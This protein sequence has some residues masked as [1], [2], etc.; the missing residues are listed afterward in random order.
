MRYYTK[1]D[2]PDDYIAINHG[3]PFPLESIAERE[4]V[5]IVDYSIS[6]VD[7]TTLLEKTE[8]V[9][10]MDHPITAINYYQDY[11]KKIAGIR[12]VGIAGCQLTYAY[13][14]NADEKSN[15]EICEDA[16][17]FF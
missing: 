1:E 4:N 12:F 7:M 5:Y 6:K 8:E 17:F 2:K 3:M 9:V 16:P 13:F 11:E 14:Q 10:W 15:E